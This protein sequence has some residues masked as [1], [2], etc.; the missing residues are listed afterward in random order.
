MRPLRLTMTAFGS[1]AQKTVLELDK[2]GAGGLYLISGD[3]GAG[4]TTI[5]DAITYALYGEAS[6]ENRKTSMLRSKYAEPD[7]L[8]EVELE[9]SYAGK[10]YIVKRGPE[11]ERPKRNGSG[12]TKQSA[13]AELHYPDGRVITKRTDVNAKIEEIMGIDHTQFMQIAMIA[14]GDF[15]KLLTAG[16]KDR[17]DIF[18]KIFKTERFQKLQKDINEDFIELKRTYD[19]SQRSIKQSVDGIL[20]DENDVLSIEVEMLKNGG[21]AYFQTETKDLL[22]KLISGD[23]SKEEELNKKIEKVQKQLDTVNQNLGEIKQLEE[24]KRELEENKKNK[25]V[26]KIRYKE[27]EKARDLERE[28]KTETEKKSEKRAQIKNEL[29]RYDSL[30]ALSKEIDEITNDLDKNTKDRDDKKKEHDNCSKEIEKLKSELKELSDAGE[31]MQKLIKERSDTE[32]RKKDA[33][34]IRGYFKEYR[35]KSKEDEIAKAECKRLSK[36]YQDLSDDYTE[37][38]RKFLE[39]QAGILAEDLEDGKPCPVCGSV[40]HPNPAKKS[41]GAPTKEQ[42]EAAKRSM[43]DEE[44]KL[45]QKSNACVRIESELNGIKQNIE[46]KAKEL[47]DEMAFEEIEK[48]N[49]SEIDILQIQLSSLDQKIEK[50][51]DRIARRDKLNKDIPNREKE[52]EQ[53]SQDLSVLTTT[54]TRLQSDKDNKSEQFE[55]EKAKLDFGSRKD[56]EEEIKK[57]EAFIK[58]REDALKKAEDDFNES[59]KKIQGY[60]SAIETLE[61]QLSAKSELD[62]AEEEEKQKEYTAEKSEYE[63][64]RENVSHRLKTNRDILKKVG[65]EFKE[66]EELGKKYQWLDALNKTANGRIEGKSKLE[67]ETYVQMTYFDRIIRSANI[68]FMEM[69]SG[70]YELKRRIDDENHQSKIGLELDVVDHYN[71]SQ[72]NVE[73]LSGGESFKASLSLALGLSDEIQAS[74]GGIKLDTMFVDEGFGSLDEES[75]DQAINTLAR[76]SDGDRLVGIISHVAEL[77]NRIDKQI[78]VTKTESGGSTAKIVL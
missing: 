61:K 21:S 57:L 63:E 52:L 32:K 3:T 69:S 44:K 16:T 50:E 11:Y 75:L 42:L 25:E 62:K 68:R 29:P 73:S 35:G 17:T 19:D 5:F 49:D 22:D 14:Q 1:Y 37:K 65:K 78:V 23:G 18:R 64:Q 60:T 34:E 74:A 58:E 2:F 7:A 66:Y 6:G 54:V 39:E 41:E 67:L 45:S 13:F 10:N 8:T 24:R 20:V 26:E 31:N 12:F 70:Q 30:D 47:Y 76:L 33:E 43:E 51:N 72:R 59:G 48:K 9:F 38:N 77:K 53:L 27:L 36:S 55:A 15:L 56:A 46:N 28:R 71:G 40:E 4:K